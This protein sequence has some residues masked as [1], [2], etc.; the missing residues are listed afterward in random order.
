MIMPTYHRKNRVEIREK[1]SVIMLRLLIQ[2]LQKGLSVLA[3][4]GPDLRES[5]RHEE[6][7]A[8][9]PIMVPDDV[10]EG[11]FAVLAVEGE[12]TQRFVVELDHLTNPAFLRL[13]EQ[14]EEE[15]G[16]TQKGALQIP[17]PP[18]E[19]QKILDRRTRE[20][21]VRTCYVPL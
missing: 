4:R 1:A 13:L 5:R 20:K 16:F 17:C 7:L 15:Y 19:L 3:P 18:H 11:H 2:K 14:A 21:S 12:E 6:E 10:T 9:E 8:E